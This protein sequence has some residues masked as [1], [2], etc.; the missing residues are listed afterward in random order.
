MARLKITIPEQLKQ[1]IIDLYISS[2]YS[3][4][5]VI[6]SGIYPGG[7]TSLRKRL[8]EW[9]VFENRLY[10]LENNFEEIL[11]A[12]ESGESLCSLQNRFKVNKKSISDK[13]R[14]LG[15][16]VI[17]HQLE[18]KFDEH[19]FDVI[20]TEEKAYWLGFIF[21]DGNISTVKNT[22]KLTEY[23][24]TITLKQNDDS[25]L[26][27]FNS[28][29]QHQKDNRHYHKTKNPSCSWY[30]NNKHLWEVLNSYGCVPRK[31]LVLNF[32]S[33]SI[34]KDRSLIRHF[35]RG[36]FDGDGCLS[37]ELRTNYIVP[38]ASLLGTKEFIQTLV[39]YLPLKD[40]LIISHNKES[41]NTYCL[42]LKVS[43][44]K[45]FL[46]YIYNNCSIYLDR[47]YNRYN[48]LKRK[49]SLEEFRGSS[50]RN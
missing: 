24:F 43:E 21:A 14:Q 16:E 3:T 27:K 28:F 17:N 32:P 45:M 48:L 44:S 12:W 46:D 33:V 41:T 38:R 13:L 19:I 47:K 8:K 34:F 20:D 35:I 40:P 42:K 26:L 11:I 49:I 15:Y 29:M 10:R 7:I 2:N 23:R 37:Y 36:Y 5:S 31:S 18:L 4:K 22:N 9:N 1:Q 25:H 6:D 30:V 50:I 39:T